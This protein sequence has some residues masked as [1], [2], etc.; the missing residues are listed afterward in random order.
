MARQFPLLPQE[1]ERR[2]VERAQ[3]GDEN[4]FAEIYYAYS[5]RIYRYIVVRTGNEADAEDVMQDVMEKVY[6]ALPRYRLG[7]APF[8]A[9]VFK[10]AYNS[11]IDWRRRNGHRADEV[12]LPYGLITDKPGPEEMVELRLALKDLGQAI[13]RL[14]ESQRSVLELRLFGDLSAAEIGK[15]L[16]KRDGNVRALLYQALLNLRKLSAREGSL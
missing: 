9:W 16:G 1:D 14:P 10:V 5:P 2:L 12:A 15:I 13:A 3:A 7:Q 11:L 4:A 8:A 6:W